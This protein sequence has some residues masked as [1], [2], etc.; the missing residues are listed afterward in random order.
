MSIYGYIIC[1][2]NNENEDEKYDLLVK[3]LNDIDIQL[4]NYSDAI[5]SSSN[6]FDRILSKLQD[7]NIKTK[8]DLDMIC[9]IIEKDCKAFIKTIDIQLNLL[10]KQWKKEISANFKR[11]ISFVPLDDIFI[12]ALKDKELE[13]FNAILNLYN[14]TMKIFNEWIFDKNTKNKYY[15]LFIEVIGKK[16]ENIDYKLAFKLDDILEEFKD[17]YT[18]L[19]NEFYLISSISVSLLATESI[20]KS[21]QNLKKVQEMNLYIKN[22][23]N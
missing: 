23:F 15:Q 9:I 1:E 5:E 13:I 6:C 20:I 16:I 17:F 19:G 7:S 8:D 4:L 12:E 18:N 2:T 14:E 21:K 10:R 11:L 3:I 22:V